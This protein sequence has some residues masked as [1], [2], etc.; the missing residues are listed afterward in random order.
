M[1]EVAE[2]Q[3]VQK[4]LTPLDLLQVALSR[5]AAIDVIERLAALQEKAQAREAEIDFNEALNRVQEQIRRVAPDLN[6]TQTNSRY[7]SYAALDR[8]VRPIYSKEGFS[9]SFNT[10]DCPKADHVRVICYVSLGAHTRTYQT[11]ICCDGKGP[12]GGDVMTKTHAEGAAASY[13]M[14]YL[15]KMIFNIAIGSEDDDGNLGSNGDLQE[16][17][18]WLQNASSKEEL[19]KLFKEAYAL[20]ETNPAALRVLV[21]AKNARKK[22]LE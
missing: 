19:T 1:S 20:F 10:G 21:D 13:G 16:R 14:R 12:K 22:E 7:A 2:T 9:L 15:L 18:E 3:L 11:D 6:N 17:I 8:K 4:P 5:D